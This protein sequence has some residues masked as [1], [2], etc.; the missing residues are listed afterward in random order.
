MADPSVKCYYVNSAF[1][2]T[3]ILSGK[4]GFFSDKFLP[5]YVSIL[6]TNVIFWYKT[7]LL[8]VILR[9]HF[10]SDV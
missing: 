5:G 2:F 7:K 9:L 6:D 1:N 8:A 4:I 3:D 10:S